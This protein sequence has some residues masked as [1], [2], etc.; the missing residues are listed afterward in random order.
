MPWAPTFA[1]GR[2]L[3]SDQNEARRR[4]FAGRRLTVNLMRAI[5]LVGL[6]GFAAA[7]LAAGPHAAAW[8]GVLLASGGAM[9]A[10]DAWAEPGY[11]RQVQGIGVLLKL[12]AV[13][14]MMVLPD[15]RVPLFWLV[16]FGSAM[17]SHAPGRLRHLRLL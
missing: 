16:V 13:A 5:H 14:L 7:L 2:A 8:G 11:L 6:A 9:M 3:R 10:L 12:A 15:V 17:L 4:D 1:S